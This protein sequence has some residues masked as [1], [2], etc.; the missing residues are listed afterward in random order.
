MDSQA[1]SPHR[2]SA[3]ASAGEIAR[4]AAEVLGP[5]PFPALVLE[6]PSQRIV[7]SSPAASQLISPGGDMIVGQLFE[8]FMA[9]SPA[10][11]SD[12]FAGGRLNGVEVSRIL[13][14][15]HREDT[16]VRMWIRSF[17]DHP[18]SMFVV[19]VLVAEDLFA[20]EGDNDE[21][22]EAPAVV[23]MADSS[24]LI[25]RI[26]GD[27]EVLFGVPVADLLG[28]SLL[29]LVDHDAVPR[30]LSALGEASASQNGVTLHLDI[31]SDSAKPRLR[32]E[33]LFLPLEPSPSVSFVF[34]PIPH[35]EQVGLQSTN[36]SAMLLR[37]GRGA[38]VAQ[39]AGTLF[40]G[41]SSTDVPGLNTLTTRELEVVARLLSGDRPPS[42]AEDL[43]L[44]Q[45]TVRN[46]LGSVYAKLGVTSQQDLLKLLRS[47]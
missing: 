4:I 39:L 40:R 19:V 7:A 33:V 27:A 44:S 29:S 15:P 18:A 32:C 8:D 34:L 35:D 6:V 13:R 26:S 31:R 41:V 22:R 14:R 1:T 20:A 17:E 46:H 43:F 10:L 5:I 9:D 12:L 45:S 28:R 2:A 37:L 11:G 16:K 25:E 3:G 42:I 24:L 38:E 36:L 30:C 23:G 47:H 21:W